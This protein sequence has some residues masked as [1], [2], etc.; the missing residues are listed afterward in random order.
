MSVYLISCLVWGKRFLFLQMEK[1]SFMGT[2][3]SLGPTNGLIAKILFIAF[4]I[5]FPSFCTML[6]TQ[7]AFN[8]YLLH[9]QPSLSVF[10]MGTSRSRWYWTL[11]RR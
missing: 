6:T 5:V 9:K 3:R 4:T 10:P 1:L 2:P 7:K 11:R 8:K